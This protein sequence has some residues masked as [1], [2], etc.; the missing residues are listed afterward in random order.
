MASN[1]NLTRELAIALIKSR[2][3]PCPRCGRA[4]LPPRYPYK[5]QNVEY[6][7]PACG[8]IYHPCKLL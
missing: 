5:K 7:C 8:E 4:T 3:V 2:E 1:T 6:R